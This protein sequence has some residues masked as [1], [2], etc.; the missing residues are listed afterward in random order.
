M[1]VPASFVSEGGYNKDWAVP[2]PGCY[3]FF[4]NSFDGVV[5]GDLNC[6]G[7]SAMGHGKKASGD[8]RPLGSALRQYCRWRI[9]GVL[10]YCKIG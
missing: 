4:Y 9:C 7:T 3:L 5:R 2:S 6:L 1:V 10:V 8:S